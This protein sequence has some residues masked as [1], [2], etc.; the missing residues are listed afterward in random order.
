MKTHLF[1]F[2]NFQQN[3]L[4]LHLNMAVSNAAEDQ[5]EWNQS[6]SKVLFSSSG[7]FLTTPDVG[8][9]N[10]IYLNPYIQ[11]QNNCKKISQMVHIFE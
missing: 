7:F 2:H 9:F 11:R 6:C 1:F 3:E 4:E 8:D 5:R 10:L